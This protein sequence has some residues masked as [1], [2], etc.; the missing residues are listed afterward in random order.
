MNAQDKKYESY[1]KLKDQLAKSAEGVLTLT[2]ELEVVPNLQAQAKA[3]LERLLAEN[4]VVLLV[5]VFNAGKSTFIN[6]LVGKKILPTSPIPKT[7][8]LCAI[9]YGEEKKI[10]MYP[11]SGEPFEIE[12]DELDK[13]VSIEHF[14]EHGNVDSAYERMEMTWPLDLCK[15]NVELIDSVGLDD[16]DGRDLI[17]L[18]HAKNADAILYLTP[19]THSASAGELGT[20]DVLKSQGFED[21][22]FIATH[23]DAIRGDE[24]EEREHKKYLEKQLAGRTGLGKEGIFYVDSRTA[25][26]GRTK[27]DEDAVAESGILEIEA[28]LEKFLVSRRGRNKIMTNVRGLRVTCDEVEK[29]LQMRRGMA[30][31]TQE[32][33]AQIR[34][35][36]GKELEEARRQM[37]AILRNV[38]LEMEGIVNECAIETL[39]FMRGLDS[40]TWINGFEPKSRFIIPTKEKIKKVAEETGAH[41]KSRLEREMNEFVRTVL[42]PKIARRLQD[43]EE[44][45]NEEGARFDRQV[46]KARAIL[47]GEIAKSV[48]VNGDSVDGSPQMWERAVCVLGAFTG[49]GI[50]SGGVGAAFGVKEM[51]KNIVAQVVAGIIA[52][53]IAGAVTLPVLVA[54]IIAG[55]L[56][57]IITGAQASDKVVGIVE[58]KFG[59]L[60]RNKAAANAQQLR[61]KIEGELK[62]VVEALEKV[63]RG[64]VENIEREAQRKKAENK[65]QQNDL[66]QEKQL[67]ARCEKRLSECRGSLAQVGDAV[68]A[69]G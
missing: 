17:T 57:A 26:R 42:E 2:R 54:A 52:V 55:A 51:V 5:G 13:Y 58:R 24:D 3:L 62:Q 39:N 23:A 37:N 21:P 11:K 27:G 63:L 61:S 20:L 59:E 1:N 19:C 29:I 10:T 46:L 30:D 4:F 44:L 16:P 8:V 22:F 6:A 28:G 34:E 12:A 66:A 36:L 64:D 18:G 50:L 35:T 7:A 25:L 68:I 60:M 45:V 14:D 65:G 32:D 40:S 56:H 53:M 33:L 38:N 47:T 15:N 9:R 48:S 67:L 41:L 43:L 49:L 31:K 69:L